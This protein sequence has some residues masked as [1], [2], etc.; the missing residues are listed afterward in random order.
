V[1]LYTAFNH[2]VASVYP[3]LILPWLLSSLVLLCKFF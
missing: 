2:N 1:R 3:S